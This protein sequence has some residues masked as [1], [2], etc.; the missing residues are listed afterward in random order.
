MPKVKV[1]QE[2]VNTWEQIVEAAGPDGLA[3]AIC[4]VGR[5][6]RSPIGNYYSVFV[7]YKGKDRQTDRSPNPPWWGQGRMMFH[8][9]DKK[10][11]LAEAI[12]WVKEHLKYPA[13]DSDKWVR[14]RMHDYVLKSV[15][16]AYPLRKD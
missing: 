3:V 14:N 12:A 9:F 6:G 1:V 2:V 15:N 7:R 4:W 10:E 8:A 13:D 16:D 11:S 5:S